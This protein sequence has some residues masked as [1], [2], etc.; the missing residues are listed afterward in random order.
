MKTAKIQIAV[1]STAKNVHM[2]EF[3]IYISS[4]NIRSQITPFSV[5]MECT[6]LTYISQ[7]IIIVIEAF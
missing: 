7:L 6:L 2:Y 1:N 5:R 4:A 3:N